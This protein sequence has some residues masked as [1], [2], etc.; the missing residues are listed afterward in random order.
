MYTLNDYKA[1]KVELERLNQQW[2]NYSGNNPNK[3]QTSIAVV[4]SK[5]RIIETTLKAVGYIP[6]TP[7][8][9]LEHRLDSAFPNARS[10]QIV[11]FEGKH[12]IRRFTP[13][14]KSLSGKTVTEWSKSW[15]E[16]S[17]K[18]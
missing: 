11:D 9:E 10:K 12:Y 17:A 7:Q 18:K 14:E 3:F 15:E 16:V 5:V 13:L 4:R 8:E 1:A 2:E 6:R